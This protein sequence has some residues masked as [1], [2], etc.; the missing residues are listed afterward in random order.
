MALVKIF[1]NLRNYA[2]GPQV[3]ISGASIAAIL[4]SL[5]E[6]NPDLC[7][8]L[9]EEGKIRPFFKIMINGHDIELAEGIDTKVNENDQ[10]AIFSPIA[11]GKQ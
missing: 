4:D 6:S 7:D 1:G 9:L 5:C 11:G 2:A 8:A 3:E 10:I